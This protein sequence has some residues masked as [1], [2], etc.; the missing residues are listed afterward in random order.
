MSK[1]VEIE[2]GDLY[3]EKHEEFVEEIG[4]R[5]ETRVRKQFEDFIHGTNQQVEREMEQ[6]EES[7]QETVTVD[8]GLVGSITEDTQ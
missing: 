5:Y 4:E 7:Q 3:A 8:E 2:V 1:K 6:V